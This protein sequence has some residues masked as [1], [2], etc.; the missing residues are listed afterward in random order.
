M[1]L[2][3]FFSISAQRYSWW[4]LAISSVGCFT[5]PDDKTLLNLSC[6][7][8]NSKFDSAS[9]T[10]AS[11][12]SIHW[13]SWSSVKLNHSPFTRLVAKI[14]WSIFSISETAGVSITLNTESSRG[15]PVWCSASRFSLSRSIF[16][17]TRPTFTYEV[18]SF[19]RMSF[20]RMK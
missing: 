3:D 13:L 8:K 18:F 12:S 6:S 19:V 15:L 1:G 10:N 4:N 2:Q 7:E 9:L 17:L 16:S 20:S 5:S 14:P 11:A